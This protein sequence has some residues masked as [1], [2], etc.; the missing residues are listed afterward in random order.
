MQRRRVLS[1][2]ALVIILGIAVSPL[3]LQ[4]PYSA[5][6]SINWGALKGT[7]YIWG[8]LG[9]SGSNTPNPNIA[10][11]QMKSFGWN[12]IRLPISWV[13]MLANPSQYS[14]TLQ[15]VATQADVNGIYVIYDF[16]QIEG[17]STQVWPSTLLNQYSNYNTF[18]TA[19]WN[20]QATL[21]G[22]SGWNAQMSTFWNQVVSA[23]K[24]YPS[25][26]GYEIMN[27]PPMV[28]GMTYANMQQYNQFIANAL[29]PMIPSN[30][31][32]FF[33]GPYSQPG[34]GKITGSSPI[35]QVA[36]IGIANLALD[37][38]QYQS[39][40]I[41]TS[42]TDFNT[43]AQN[44]KL[45][46]V[47]IGEWATCGG[48]TMTEST[49]LPI[50]QSYESTFRQ[51]GFA[52]S[53]WGYWCGTTMVNLLDSNCNSYW[54]DSDIEQAQGSGSTNTQFSTTSSLT[55][56]QTTSVDTISTT[57]S[58]ATNSNLILSLLPPIS[59]T[60]FA[61]GLLIIMVAVVMVAL[62]KRRI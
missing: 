36:P 46:G 44:L 7:N 13:A 29:S 56:T 25:T 30:Q 37:G 27:E 18:M 28:S 58:T 22:Q 31:Y 1:S 55:S 33:M 48:C 39:S 41:L 23:V 38:H 42:F 26:L 49:A 57:R 32:I 9:I 40:G 43:A 4:A 35:E 34:G 61:E 17:W 53:Y 21:N 8:P 24:S 12:L 14:Q 45:S 59:E 62:I 54:L 3:L 11:P 6:S 20:N 47:V 15:Q 52:N 10:F 19:W 5:V 51:Y 2:L 60:Q 50:V 16:H